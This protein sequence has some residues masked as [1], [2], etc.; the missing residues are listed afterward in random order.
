MRQFRADVW[1]RTRSVA[2]GIIGE[3]NSVKPLIGP[4]PVDAYVTQN[5]WAEFPLQRLNKFEGQYGLL[6]IVRGL[7]RNA[8]EL[9]A[10]GEP[11]QGQRE[12]GRFHR[13]HQQQKV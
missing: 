3:D 11:Y 12:Y 2:S 9:K 13:S 6:V 7:A 8:N 10:E 1:R 4:T 5:V